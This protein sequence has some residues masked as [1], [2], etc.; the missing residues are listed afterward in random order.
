M[1]YPMRPT[2]T[3]Q[4]VAWIGVGFVVRRSANGFFIAVVANLPRVG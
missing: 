1:R 4:P 3:S 2:N